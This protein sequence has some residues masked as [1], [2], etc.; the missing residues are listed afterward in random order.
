MSGPPSKGGVAIRGGSAQASL[1]LDF[2]QV[3]ELISQQLMSWIEFR[4]MS[5]VICDYSSF[6]LAMAKRS[7]NNVCLNKIVE[8]ANVIGFMQFVD[9]LC[10]SDGEMN[11]IELRLSNIV[12]CFWFIFVF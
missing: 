8:L 6:C 7:D 12:N 5:S 10:L 9:S 2:S 11:D 3:V 4:A 1:D